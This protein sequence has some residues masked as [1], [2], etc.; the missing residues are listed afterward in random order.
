MPNR[1]MMMKTPST[2]QGSQAKIERQS[3]NQRL[4][5]MKTRTISLSKTRMQAP[6]TMVMVCTLSWIYRTIF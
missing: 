2:L 4:R 3:G 6:M 1:R 5:M